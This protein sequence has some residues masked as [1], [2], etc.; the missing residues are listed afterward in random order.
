VEY[1]FYFLVIVLGLAA[2]VYKVRQLRTSDRRATRAMAQPRKNI[3]DRAAG[4]LAAGQ[5]ELE[6]A[7]DLREVR[8]PWGWPGNRNFRPRQHH[9]ARAPAQESTE[10]GTLQHWVDRLVSEKQKTTDRAY[11]EHLEASMKALLEDRFHSA[12]KQEEDSGRG[13]GHDLVKK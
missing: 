5:Q 6:M 8:V 2:C 10:Q 4:S 3:E 11:Q 12:G 13:N 9:H 1:T 7:C